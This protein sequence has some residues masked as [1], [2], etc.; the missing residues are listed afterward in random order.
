M[1][2]PVVLDAFG[3]TPLGGKVIQIV[4][5]ADPASRSFLVKIQL[6]SNARLHTGLS[7]KARFARGERRSF[8]IPRSAIVTR[9]QLQAVYSVDANRIAGLRYIT[10][11]ARYR[12]Q[13]EVLS[14][15]QDGE[16]IVAAPESRDLS[17]KRIAA[18][19]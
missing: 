8:L 10:L 16:Q 15:I 1:S 11:G 6:P 7:G 3:D 14:G 5:A 13:I 4:P 19:P 12:D 9:G 2:A 17:G 18:K